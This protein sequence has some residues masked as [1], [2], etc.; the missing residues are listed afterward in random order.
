MNKKL[1]EA[2]RQYMIALGKRGGDAT[3]KKYGSSHFKQL[4]EKSQQKLLKKI[5]S[6]PY[7]S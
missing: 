2:R 7:L 3:K 1:K 4:G 5:S 6:D